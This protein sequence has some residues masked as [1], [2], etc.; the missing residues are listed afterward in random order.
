MNKN[1][2]K[3]RIIEDILVVNVIDKCKF[4]Y[5]SKCLRIFNQNHRKLGY[6]LFKTDELGISLTKYKYFI[7]DGFEDYIQFKEGNPNFYEHIKDIIY[8]R[9]QLDKFKDL[10]IGKIED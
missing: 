2:I 4:E 5:K 1:E 6:Y 10:D 9:L 8:R 7:S 3:K